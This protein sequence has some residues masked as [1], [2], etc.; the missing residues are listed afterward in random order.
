MAHPEEWPTIESM[1]RIHISRF[2]RDRGVFQ[3]LQQDV[4]PQLAAMVLSQGEHELRCWSI[5][6]AA[7]EEAYTLAIMWH[8]AL[9]SCF[10]SLAIRIVGTDADPQAL[11]R[12]K[13]ACYPASSLKD[14]PTEWREAAFEISNKEFCLRRL[15]R[16]SVIF[17][18]QDLRYECPDQTF[19]MILCRYV[20]FTYFDEALQQETLHRILARLL[21]SGALIIGQTE[22][23]LA[24]SQDLIIPWHAQLRIYRKIDESARSEAT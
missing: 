23:L 15:Y 6:C 14:L 20:V 13:K 9:A 19:H 8:Q 11:E 24:D 18:Q 1:C 16:D 4:I 10:P 2:Y 3:M 21:P 5:G 22:S 12:A 17:L 7:G